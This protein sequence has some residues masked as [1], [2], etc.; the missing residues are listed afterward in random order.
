M[1]FVG[2]QCAG[3]RRLACPARE[4]QVRGRAEGPMVPVGLKAQLVGA[5]GE[6]KAGKEMSS[7][8]G[9]GQRGGCGAWK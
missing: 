1:G 2:Q 5:A 8:L 3:G 6:A 4:Q 7:G 9:W